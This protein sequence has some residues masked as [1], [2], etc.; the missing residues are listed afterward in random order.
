MMSDFKARK[1]SLEAMYEAYNRRDVPAMVAALDPRVE[2]TNML[3]GKPLKGRDAVGAYWTE[4][5]ELLD[6]EVSPLTFEPIPDGR[7]AVTAAQTIRNPDGSLW[8]ND[9]VIHV[10]TFGADGLILRMDPF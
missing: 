2:W 1:A 9:K 8:G 6:I 7:L 4:Q 3:D 5:F 10:I